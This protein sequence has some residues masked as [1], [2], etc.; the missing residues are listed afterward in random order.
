[1]IK[2]DNRKGFKETYRRFSS[3]CIDTIN[4]LLWKKTWT[5][6]RLFTHQTINFRRPSQEIDRHRNRGNEYE[7]SRVKFNLSG[8]V[9]NRMDKT[10]VIGYTLSCIEHEPPIFHRFSLVPPLY[11]IL[12]VKGEDDGTELGDWEESRGLK[13]LWYFDPKKFR[14]FKRNLELY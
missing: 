14:F 1:M 2:A 11:R 13:T 3:T 10:K 12:R 6:S 5:T 7:R 4:S 8:F 9:R